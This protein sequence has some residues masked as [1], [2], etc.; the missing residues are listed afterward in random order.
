MPTVHPPHRLLSIQISTRFGLSEPG[1]LFFGELSAIG[2]DGSVVLE[3]FQNLDDWQVIQDFTRPGLYGLETSESVGANGSG[4]S[5]RY[6]W[7]PGSIG[8]RGIRPG[9]PEEPIPA[10]VSKR[11]LELT[12]AEVGDVRTVG[13]TTFSIPLKISGVV[14]YFPTLDPFKKPFAVVDLKTFNHHANLHSPRPYGGSNELW[15]QLADG[16]ADATNVAGLLGQEGVRVRESFLASEMVNEQV[17]QP[18]VNAGWG[19]LLVLMFLA[20]VLASAS[21]VM[22]FS[23]I[24]TG[25]RRTEFAVLRTLGSSRR[26][27]NGAVWFS[28]FLV[29]VCG[30]GLGTV[31][32]Q[33]IGTSLLPLME[34]AEQGAKVTPRMVFQ[35][36]WTTLAVSYIIL[37]AAT[38]ATVLWLIWFTAKLEVQQLLRIGEG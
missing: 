37:V 31:V 25:E 5:A 15:V 23:F 20:L 33:L 35:I 34:V 36:D 28:L 3:D 19:A 17:E 6:S 1:A 18:L 14:D 21:G 4:K 12:D 2:P 32:G 10:V 24:D 26:Q 27:L 7:A 38:G 11:F 8:L 22:L 16:G 9:P 29:A 13:M 30:I